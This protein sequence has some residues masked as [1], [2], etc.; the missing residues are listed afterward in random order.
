MIEVTRDGG[1]KVH[2]TFRV[3]GVCGAEVVCVVGEFNDWSTTAH[4]MERDADGGFATTIALDPGRSYRFRYLLDGKRWEN[5]WAADSYVPNEFGGDDSL[6][7]LRTDHRR[8]AVFGTTDVDEDKP[9]DSPRGSV[10]G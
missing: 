6:L 2:V 5:D 9:H 7:D 10:A 4:S 8:Q 3:P 1:S